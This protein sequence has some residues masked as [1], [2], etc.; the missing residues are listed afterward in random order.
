[1]R[2]CLSALAPAAKNT[3]SK[4]GHCSF[5]AVTCDD[6]DIKK[7]IAT[8]KEFHAGNFVDAAEL[9]KLR[10]CGW[11][12]PSPPDATETALP[13]DLSLNNGHA[14]HSEAS[15]GF[16]N[17]RLFLVRLRFLPSRHPAEK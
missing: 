7:L 3:Y 5:G 17:K 15:Y 10:K 6:A 8:E 2:S 1:V 12:L 9:E 13:T 11:C 4:V 14:T 16:G